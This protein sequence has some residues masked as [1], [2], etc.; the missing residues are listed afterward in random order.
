M[1]VVS[2]AALLD[3]S[4]YLIFPVS[5]RLCELMTTHMAT[6]HCC[7]LLILGAAF[8]QWM[9]SAGVDLWKDERLVDV[10]AL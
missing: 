3:V 5:A 8:V 7:W 1:W 10:S 2:Y 6:C 4:T 9:F